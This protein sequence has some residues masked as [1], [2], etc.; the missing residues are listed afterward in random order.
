[1]YWGND[2]L[3]TELPHLIANFSE[4]QLDQASY[5]LRIGAEVYVS[6]T[7]EP[8]DTNR[9]PKRHLETGDGFAIP[10]GQFGFILTEETVE[11]PKYAIAFISMRSQYKFRGLV[12]VSGFHVDPNYKGRLLF[13]VFNAGPKTVHLSRGEDCFLIWYASIDPPVDGPTKQGFCD[14]PSREISFVSDGVLSLS[15]L[16]SRIKSVEKTNT[17]LMTVG[18]IVLTLIVSLFLVMVRVIPVPEGIFCEEAGLQ[19]NFDQPTTPSPIQ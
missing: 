6:P 17:I 4:S 11:V 12:N 9:T 7:G 19:Q 2:R 1:M 16:E 18:P 15:R 13:S 8:G 10:S 3:R 5:R 14:I